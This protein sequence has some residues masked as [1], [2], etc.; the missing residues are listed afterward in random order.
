[1]SSPE[2]TAQTIL[3][4]L[5]KSPILENCD[6]AT[7]ASFTEQSTLMSVEKGQVLFVH[8]EPAKR[9]FIILSGWVKLFRETL[10]GSQAVVDILPAGHMLGETSI[11]QNDSYPYSAESIESAKLISLPLTLLKSEID[12]N[13]KVTSA[14]LSNM[15]KVRRKQDQELEHLTIQSAPQRIGC[16]LLR[17]TNQKQQG[18]ITIQLP[19]DK[20]LVAARLGMQPETFSRALTRLKDA[21][22]LEI[23]GSTIAL[24]DVRQL[25]QYSCAACSSEFPCKDLKTN[26]DHKTS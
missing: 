24:D 25:I 4:I 12:N 5:E 7:L 9:F 6:A 15:A 19:Y 10:D 1:M 11:F 17:L 20:S 16:F 13:P 21:I 26:G 23:H 18:P 8:E 2:S 14:M 3:R 22:G